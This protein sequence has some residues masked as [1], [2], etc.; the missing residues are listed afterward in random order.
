[1]DLDIFPIYDGKLVRLDQPSRIMENE[2]GYGRK[3]F[4]VFVKDGNKIKRLMFGDPRLTWEGY[5]E[6]RKIN[7]IKRYRCLINEPKDKT[8]VRYWMCRMWL[9]DSPQSVA[10]GQGGFPTLPD[11]PT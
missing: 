7:F 8:K 3:M 11:T 2:A 4:K 6:E 5:S 10:K 9:A 1:M